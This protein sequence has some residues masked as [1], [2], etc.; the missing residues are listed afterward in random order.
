M[1]IVFT[2]VEMFCSIAAKRVAPDVP[3]DAERTVLD[4]LE[5]ELKTTQADA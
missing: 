2:P 1:S 4:D 3:K 5:E